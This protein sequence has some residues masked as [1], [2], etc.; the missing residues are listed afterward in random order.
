MNQVLVMLSTEYSR[1]GREIDRRHFIS[2][3]TE[4]GRGRERSHNPL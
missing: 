2:L 4:K 3:M 1:V